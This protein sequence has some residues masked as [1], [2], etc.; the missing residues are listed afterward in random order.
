MKGGTISYNTGGKCVSFVRQRLCPFIHHRI[1]VHCAV[2]NIKLQHPGYCPLSMYNYPQMMKLTY[3]AHTLFLYCSFVGCYSFVRE[4][5][6]RKQGWQ[7]NKPIVKKTFIQCRTSMSN[8]AC[9]PQAT[10]LTCLMQKLF[11]GLG[12]LLR[13][14]GTIMKQGSLPEGVDSLAGRYKSGPFKKM[15]C[16]L[17]KYIGEQR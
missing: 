1:P 17:Q 8:E 11:L 3:R 5:E 4:K 9:G 15:L 13:W 10:S 16:M 7:F 14:M 6:E 2:P 12:R